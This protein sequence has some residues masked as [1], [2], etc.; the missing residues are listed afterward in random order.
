M[1]M[2]GMK[3]G[4][5]RIPVLLA[6]FAP[7]LWPLGAHAQIAAPRE[8]A[9]IEFG[10]VS[11]YPS[12]Q[13]ADAGI[14]ENVF[15][16][17]SDPKRDVTLTVSSQAL[18]VW[19]VGLNELLFSSGSDYLWFK[20]YAS[21]R[22]TNTNYAMRFNLSAS[23]FKPYVGAQHVRSSTRP[24]PEIDTRA[25]RVTR[26]AV[27]GSSFSLTERTAITASAQWDETTFDDGER[28]RG[29]DLA[30]GM[31]HVA[32]SYGGGF[33]YVV[34]PFTTVSI[35]GNYRQQIFPESHLR[36]SKSYRVTPRVDFAPEAV[37]RGSFSAGYEVFVPD[38][39]ELFRNQGVV[40]EGALNWTIASRTL[41][42]LVARRNVNYSY[43]DNDPYYLQ[44]G[45]RLTV[46]Q[47]LT[48][49]FGLQGA[50]ERQHLSYRWRRGVTPT[51]GLEHRIDMSDIFSAGVVVNV[52]RG[53]SV[54]VGAEK[55]K[56]HSS[57]DAR[58]NF[59]RTRLLSGV[60]VGK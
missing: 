22:S 11:V 36:D 50:A 6:C 19:R 4:E 15:N 58:Q 24:T 43:L 35:N 27:A 41:F 53:L 39:P 48:N 60:T 20:Q 38:D 18:A 21:E 55:A 40:L 59:R 13:I 9:Q 31:N 5:F 56:R 32:R 34:T 49:R 37:I 16:D 8:S 30:E 1:K 47:R 25:R 7:L 45:A 51:P 46:T 2:D 14:D 54:F 26:V 10:P 57:Q 23:R 3:V 17:G 44:T 42:D 52:G 12:L 33:R 28:F 29:V